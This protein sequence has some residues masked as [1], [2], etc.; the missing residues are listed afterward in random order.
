[1]FLQCH[2]LALQ[3]AEFAAHVGDVIAHACDLVTLIIA[4]HRIT[5]GACLHFAD[6]KFIPR[7]HVG[8]VLMTDRLVFILD[9]AD[10]Q[11]EFVF[12][13]VLCVGRLVV[14]QGLQFFHFGVVQTSQEFQFLH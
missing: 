12:E 13:E 3:V 11:C 6:F 14:E 4:F 8:F 7:L 1:L 9:I 2:I 10:G 5:I